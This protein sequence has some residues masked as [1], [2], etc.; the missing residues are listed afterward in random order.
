VVPRLSKTDLA[1]FFVAREGYDEREWEEKLY[2][3]SFLLDLGVMLCEPSI[4]FDGLGGEC[5]WGCAC[6]VVI[7]HAAIRG[8]TRAVAA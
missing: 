6:W 8:E 3:H 7:P 5:I 1:A 4:R 2:M